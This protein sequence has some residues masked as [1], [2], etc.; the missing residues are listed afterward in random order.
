MFNALGYGKG[1]SVL[2]AVSI[3]LGCPACVAFQSFHRIIDLNPSFQAM[4]TLDIWKTDT[5]V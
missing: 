4:A 2:A 5:Y 1:N 3:V